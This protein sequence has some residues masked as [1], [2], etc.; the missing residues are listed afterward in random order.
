MTTAERPEG[1][2]TPTEGKAWS[3]DEAFLRNLGLIS[4]A[5]QRRL[6]ESRVAI[7][8]MGGVGGVHLV[9]LARLGIGRFTIA[10]PDAFETAN[11]NRQYGATL[12]NMGRGKAEAMGQEALQI[13]PEL[14]LRVLHERVTAANVGDFLE[15][16]SV[17]LDGIDFFSFDC[18]TP[19]FPRG[20][21]ARALGNHGR[22]DRFQRGLAPLRPPRDGF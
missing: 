12:R 3:Y 4:S 16:A 10:D 19:P 11:F 20:A 14:D 21:A 18:A 17:V 15:G 8:G 5:E 22:T 9:T 6:R 1:G 13:N 7:A 2:S